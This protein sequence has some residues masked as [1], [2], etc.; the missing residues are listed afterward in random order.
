MKIIYV[1]ANM[2]AWISTSSEEA[3][4]TYSEEG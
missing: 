4:A 2:S 1:S 3:S